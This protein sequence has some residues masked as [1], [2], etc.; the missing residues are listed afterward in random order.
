MIASRYSSA[1]ISVLLIPSQQ[2]SFSGNRTVLMFQLSIAL[3]LLGPVEPSNACPPCVGGEHMYSEPARLIPSRRTS[4]F[5]A[6]RSLLPSTCSALAAGRPANG[7]ST[8]PPA[9]AVP[10]VPA[11]PLPLCPPLPVV[12]ELPGPEPPLPV[13]SFPFA[14]PSSAS[15]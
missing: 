12:P 9:P 1:L 7:S 5:E 2:C 8:P 10:V 15:N 13:T 6:S 3:M 4:A 14:H 11:G